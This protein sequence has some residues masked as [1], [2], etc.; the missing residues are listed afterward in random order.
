MDVQTQ[1]VQIRAMRSKWASCSSS[2]NMTVS[3]DLPELPHSW[4]NM[5]FAIN[6]STYFFAGMAKAFAL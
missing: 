3:V 5:S 1:R 4:W 6:S 2:G